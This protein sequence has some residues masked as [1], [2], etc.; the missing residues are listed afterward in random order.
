[1]M[2]RLASLQLA[3]QQLTSI[4]SSRETVHPVS[5][6]LIMAWPGGTFCC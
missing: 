3:H 4:S 5:S 6:T 2:T 1:L